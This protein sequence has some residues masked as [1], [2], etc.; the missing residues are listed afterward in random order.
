MKKTGLLGRKFQGTEGKLVST[1][2]YV[3]VE[4]ENETGKQEKIVDKCIKIG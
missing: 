2:F 3:E 1:P 4:Y